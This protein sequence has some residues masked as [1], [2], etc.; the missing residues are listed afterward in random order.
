MASNTTEMR[1]ILIAVALVGELDAETLPMEVDGKVRAH[2]VTVGSG[3]AVSV[4][5][6]AQVNV[7]PFVS[8]QE[9]LLFEVCGHPAILES[10]VG[11]VSVWRVRDADCEPSTIADELP[12]RWST[13]EHRYWKRKRAALFT[14]PVLWFGANDIR[15][16]F[17]KGM[18]GSGVY[19]A[20]GELI[21]LINQGNEFMAT[22]V[23]ASEITK[24][25]GR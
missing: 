2:C 25:L 24:A 13:V 11:R 17:R 23:T 14:R 6:V 20:D 12:S 8:I 5:H 1:R 4:A 19:N 10:V 16:R 15:G 22:V 7:G 18:S 3:L 21:G 9:M